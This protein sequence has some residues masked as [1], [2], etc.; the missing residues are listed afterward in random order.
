MTSDDDGNEIRF[1]GSI[2]AYT[3]RIICAYVAAGMSRSFTVLFPRKSKCTQSLTTCLFVATRFWR[4]KRPERSGKPQ[5][6]VAMYVSLI[7]LK[8]RPEKMEQSGF[9]SNIFK[10]KKYI[11]RKKRKTNVPSNFR[12]LNFRRKCVFGCSSRNNTDFIISRP[13]CR[14][15]YLY[16]T[17]FMFIRCVYIYTLYR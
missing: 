3:T 4:A 16:F 2:T 15:Q 14:S 6:V 7:E 10:I 5:I 8:T 11:C 12:E 9:P 1:S 13:I 17:R